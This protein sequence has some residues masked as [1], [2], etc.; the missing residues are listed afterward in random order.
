QPRPAPDQRRH[1]RPDLAVG[2]EVVVPATTSALIAGGGTRS[3][4]A[5]GEPPAPVSRLAPTPRAHLELGAQVA[6]PATAWARNSPRIGGADAGG[7]P[8]A[9]GHHVQ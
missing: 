7:A 4:D 6:A 9:G 3:T 8:G 2:A 1:S 5:V